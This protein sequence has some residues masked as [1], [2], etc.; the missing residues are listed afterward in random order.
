MAGAIRLTGFL[1]PSLARLA[2]LCLALLVGLHSVSARAEPIPLLDRPDF[3]RSVGPAVTYLRDRHHSLT[4]A[5][6]TARLDRFEPVATPH[7]GFGLTRDTIWL[8]FSVVNRSRSR[9]VWRLDIGRQYIE[10]LTA[11]IVR[12]GRDPEAILAHRQTDP[13]FARPVP[14]RVLLADFTL[15]PGE[16]ADFLIAYRSTTTTFLPV[17]VGTADAVRAAHAREM[18][19]DMATNGALLAMILFALLMV[20]VIGWRLGLA[21]SGYVLAGIFYVTIADGYAMQVLWPGATWLNEPMNLASLL[22]LSMMAMVFVRQLFS[23]RLAA[24][25]FDRFLI[26]FGALAGLGAVLAVPLISQRWFMVPAYFIPPLATLVSIGAAIVALRTGQVGAIAYFAGALMV[27][28]SF[29]YATVAH[30]V[31]GRFDLDATLD[32]GHFTLFTECL[33]FAV[34]ILLRLMAMRAQR[35]EA[36]RAELDVSREKLQL[37]E[38]LLQSQRDYD[39]AR[40]LSETRLRQLSELG[41]D[42]RQPL[43]ALRQALGRQ[44]GLDE[45]TT[46][47]I[48]SAFDYIEHLAVDRG[49]TGAGAS[50]IP[51]SVERFPLRIVFDNVV[52]IFS[53]KARAHG[54]RLRSRPTDLEVEADPVALMRAIGNLVDNAIVHG[55]G[56]RVLLAARQ[57]ADDVRIEVRDNGRGMSE[58]E[59]ARLLRR[60]EKGA[61]SQGQGLG[62]AIVRQT[63]DELGLRFELRTLEGRGSAAFIYVPAS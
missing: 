45:E 38:R 13:L 33:A 29:A 25:A 50:R 18:A 16:T 1:S 60:G 22:A 49:N 55:E 36:L 23:F 11:H 24:P 43:I 35:D 59:R 46:R 31:P 27:F 3:Y 8:H 47:Q 51:G 10:R 12:E 63:C 40:Q 2:G 28:S 21:F 57:R 54:A 53:E 9:G 37:S 20:P 7:V 41:H 62:L 30:L 58:A 42:I 17:A 34:A 15:P 32:F 4:P 61:A 6:A 44:R 19:I 52:H 5:V 39:A 14:G 56:K 26:G 48:D